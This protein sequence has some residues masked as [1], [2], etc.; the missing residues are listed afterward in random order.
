ME[1]VRKLFDTDEFVPRWSCGDWSPALAW[2]HMVSDFLI[3]IA[4]AAIPASLFFIAVRRRDFPKS[5]ILFLFVAFIL[6]CGLTHLVEAF[7]FYFP[8]YRFSALM[9]VVT[10]TVSLTTAVVL[11]LVLPS[12]MDLPGVRQLNE[13]LNAA[14]S[15]ERTAKQELERTRDQL[16]DRAAQMTL[17][18]RRYTEALIAALAVA[19]RWELESGRIVWDIGFADAIRATGHADGHRMKS[20]Q[21]LLGADGADE[22]RRASLGAIEVRRPLDIEL[23]IPSIPEYVLRMSASPEPVVAGQPRMMIGMFRIIPR[24]S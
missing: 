2:T 12:I 4:Y 18:T 23:P 20:W 3:F 6:S 10:A 16:E 15:G 22:M 5:K 14:M 7:M 9:K 13:Q 24:R 19:C 8:V 17:H 1:F 11:V 21:D